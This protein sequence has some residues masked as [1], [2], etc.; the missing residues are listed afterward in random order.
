MR[1]STTPVLLLAIFAVQATAQPEPCECTSPTGCPGLCD[2]VNGSPYC[3]NDCGWPG[4]WP[5]SVCAGQG[6]GNK[7]CFFDNNDECHLWTI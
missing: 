4:D 3:K 2:Q 7:N 5:C 1:L 6:S